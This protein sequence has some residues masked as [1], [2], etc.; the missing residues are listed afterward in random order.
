MSDVKLDT[1]LLTNFRKALAAGNITIRVG[2]MGADAS[3]THP[4]PEG[5]KAPKEPLSNAQVGAFHELDG[6][7]TKLPRRSFLQVPLADNFAKK[8]SR[9]AAASPAFI[10]KILEGGTLQ[11]YYDLCEVVALAVVEEAFDTSGGGKWPSSD[12]AKKKVHQTLVETG[13]LRESIDTKQVKGNG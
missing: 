13:A 6:K 9:S 8:L 5:K 7:R 10:R 1:K 11:P 4:P 3:Q 12:M 2:I